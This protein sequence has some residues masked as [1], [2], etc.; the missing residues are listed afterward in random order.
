[1]PEVS[2]PNRKL[3]QHE[4]KSAE[5]E[6]LE[7]VASP[8]AGTS[9]D[10]MLAPGYWAN[11][12]KQ[13]KAGQIIQIWPAGGAWWAEMLVRNV[14]PFAAKVHVLRSVVFDVGAPKAEPE[15]TSEPKS[16][17]KIQWRGPQHKFAVFRVADNT[18]LQEGFENKDLAGAWL[19][20]HVKALA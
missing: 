6:R 7:S 12:A 3:A 11:V 2:K 13:M 16:D 15:E 4:F 18:L 20:T 14:Q 5:Y 17:Y 8:E 10:E 19:D 1:M 9:L